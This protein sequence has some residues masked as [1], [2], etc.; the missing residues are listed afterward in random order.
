MD[1]AIVD[2][3]VKKYLFIQDFSKSEKNSLNATFLDHVQGLRP[4]ERIEKAVEKNLTSSLCFVTTN[5][6]FQY[7]QIWANLR[8]SI[9]LECQRKREKI[10]AFTKQENHSIKED[11]NSG[12]IWTSEI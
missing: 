5:P 6:K 10:S 12:F 3:K 8:K 9:L 7:C 2:K 1:M 4:E 11:M